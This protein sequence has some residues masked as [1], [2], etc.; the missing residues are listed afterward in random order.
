M[1]EIA[2]RR[3][4]KHSISETRLT[5]EF[6]YR[7]RNSMAHELAKKG[8]RME[9]EWCWIEEEPIDIEAIVSREMLCNDLEHLLD[10]TYAFYFINEWEVTVDDLKKKKKK[11]YSLIYIYIYVLII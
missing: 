4:K 1:D 10:C 3:H 8:L 5:V 9:G 2:S 7:E 6:I 11:Q